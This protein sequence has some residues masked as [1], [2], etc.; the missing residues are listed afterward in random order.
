MPRAPVGPHAEAGKDGRGRQRMGAEVIRCAGKGT[1]L[2]STGQRPP[3]AVSDVKHIGQLVLAEPIYQTGQQ[4]V[5]R[6]GRCAVGNQRESVG[7]FTLGKRIDPLGELITG[8]F[9]WNIGSR[10]ELDAT[11]FDE[12][13]DEIFLWVESDQVRDDG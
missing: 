5:G 4:P 12:D 11:G 10:G 9:G 1:A 7:T 8:R 6:Q 3:P 13:S 2:L